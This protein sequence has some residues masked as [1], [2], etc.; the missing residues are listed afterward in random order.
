M[1]RTPTI[2]LTIP[3]PIG[4]GLSVALL[5]MGL[6]LPIYAQAQDTADRPGTRFTFKLADL[7]GPGA[8]KSEANPPKVIPI[9]ADATLDVPA[10]FKVTVFAEGLDHPRNLLVLPNGDV[11][12]AESSA[13]KI[14]LLR[15]PDGR[16]SASVKTPFL[17]GLAQP[18]GLALKDKELFV[19][20]TRAVW[21]TTYIAGQDKG[22][23]LRPVTKPGQ[24]GNNKVHWTRNLALAPDGESLF[25]AIGS[26][27][28]IAE[29]PA[30]KASIQRVKLS[31]G[32]M[33]AYAI[34][35]R[36]PVGLAIE[37]KSRVLFTV[38]NERDGEG[39]EM[40]PDYMTGV[41]EGAFYGWPYAYLGPN[42]EPSMKG[43][44][45]DLVQATIAPDLLFRSHSAP[46]G[47]TFYTGTQFP[48]RFR[49][50][51]FVAHRGSW[52]AAQPR[53]YKIVFVPMI[54]GKP[55]GFYETFAIGFRQGGD[56]R[57]EVWGRPAGLAVAK[58][59]SL[60]IADDTSKRVWRISYTGN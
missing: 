16:G 48:E 26:E 4:V 50:G 36:N 60:L 58:D 12:V 45:P 35:L 13:G 44:R 10:G 14:T 57:A 3:R 21:R 5:A 47:L 9:P 59:G 1:T 46:I 43:K 8:T 49:N 41:K 25:L 38:V 15:D 33:S 7:V 6:T 20:D 18:F 27:S 28:N 55:E 2:C 42:E 24:M 22:A 30:P 34:G 51:A 37:P 53:G 54:E 52:N 56:K 29:D 32:T 11:L 17:E 19:A 40:V 31:D 39:D 23:E